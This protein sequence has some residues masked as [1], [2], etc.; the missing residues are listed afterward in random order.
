MDMETTLNNALARCAVWVHI[1][2]EMHPARMTE[3][4]GSGTEAALKSL[5]QCEL[6]D[7]QAK[8]F[9][10]AHIACNRGDPFATIRA[11]AKIHMLLEKER[12]RLLS[13]F[14]RIRNESTT[15][16]EATLIKVIDAVV[17][18][19]PESGKSGVIR[20]LHVIFNLKQASIARSIGVRDQFVSN[21]V[22]ALDDRKR[23]EV[24]TKYGHLN[25]SGQS[26]S[27]NGS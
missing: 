21:V 16:D 19:E 12:Q 26:K 9:G 4:D 18:R 15:I 1:R 8:Y 22:R 6:S 27:R 5:G 24:R 7:K 14:G 11:L 13:S 23:A 17:E 2:T 25:T 3:D 20:V 10:K